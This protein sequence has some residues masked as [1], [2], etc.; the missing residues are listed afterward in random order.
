MGWWSTGIM[1]GDTPLDF[2]DE[3]Y[4][5]CGVDKFY[6]SWKIR[7]LP[8]KAILNSLPKLLKYIGKQKEDRE[9]GY[10]VLGILMMR[11]AAPISPDLKEKMIESAKN[12][13]WALENSERRD[14]MNSFIET[15]EKYDS[16]KPIMI[17]TPGLVET[18][19][20]HIK[21]GNKGLVNL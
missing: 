9:I 2:E 17:Q 12:D 10:Q 5:I 18:I 16:S 4:E 6:D 14:R 15:L 19:L 20:E 8:R 7:P 1:G 3:F 13:Q 21:N 11:V